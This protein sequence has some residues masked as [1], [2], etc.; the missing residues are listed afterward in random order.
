[1]TLKPYPIGRVTRQ[2]VPRPAGLEL[3]RVKAPGTSR[4]GAGLGSTSPAWP[5]PGLALLR[6]VPPLLEAAARPRVSGP[7]VNYLTR[8]PALDAGGGWG[9]ETSRP[10]AGSEGVS[11]R[12]RLP[13]LTFTRPAWRPPLDFHPWDVDGGRRR[14]IEDLVETGRH[15]LEIVDRRHHH[16]HHPHWGILLQAP[17]F[18]WTLLDAPLTL[19]DRDSSSFPSSFLSPLRTFAF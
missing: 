6:S 11:A 7:A 5:V 15:S 14:A 9:R 16:R 10:G 2:P 4:A 3:P 18:A 1:M 17:P 19:G 13:P 8:W 12:G